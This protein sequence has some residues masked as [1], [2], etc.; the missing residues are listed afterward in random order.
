[1]KIEKIKIIGQLLPKTEKASPH[2]KFIL[3]SPALVTPLPKRGEA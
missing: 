3:I 2:C 1:M